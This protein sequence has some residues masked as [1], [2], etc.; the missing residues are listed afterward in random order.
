MR[1]LVALVSVLGIACG[2]HRTQIPAPATMD[3]VIK[4]FFDAVQT[5][6]VQRM[7]RLWGTARGPAAEWMPDSV[8]IMRMTIVQRYLTANGYRIIEGPLTVP[9]TTERKIYRVELQ[10]PDCNHVQPIELIHVKQGGWLIYDV[11]L[12]SAAGAGVQCPPKP[13]GTGP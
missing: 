9:G 2:G 4:Q 13:G 11:H 10:R 8:L 6:D 5:R 3:D 1:R 12:E 7:G